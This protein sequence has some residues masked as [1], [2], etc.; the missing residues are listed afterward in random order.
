MITSATPTERLTWEAMTYGKEPPVKPGLM[1]PRIKWGWH[2]RVMICWQ[3]VVSMFQ[4]AVL[5]Y[6]RKCAGWR[7][8]SGH[9]GLQHWR[10]NRPNFLIRTAGQLLR[11]GNQ[12]KVKLDGQSHQNS[13]SLESITI[14][15]QL[16][17]TKIRK[18]DQ[19]G[20]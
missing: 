9:E 3:A 18:Y 13:N 17:P 6:K 2:P 10:L 16:N 8:S 14:F 20:W 5:A 4:C 19:V 11:G 1:R 7:Y 12:L 15:P